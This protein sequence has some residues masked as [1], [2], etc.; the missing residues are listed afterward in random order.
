MIEQF[1]EYVRYN[2]IANMPVEMITNGR[3]E[4]P[5]RILIQIK[6]EL[7]YLPS[8]KPKER[9]RIV[10]A[11]ATPTRAGGGSTCAAGAAAVSKQ[12]TVR[13]GGEAG[14]LNP[15]FLRDIEFWTRTEIAGAAPSP[16]TVMKK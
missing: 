12:K 6:Y 5:S 2:A 11:A 15:E 4:L 3:D 7:G 1:E 8:N 16:A 14:S 9:V 10:G 13:A